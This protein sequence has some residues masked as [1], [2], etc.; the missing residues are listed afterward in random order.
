MT[1]KN[2]YL[3]TLVRENG[4]RDVYIPSLARPEN[5]AIM[6]ASKFVNTTLA[7]A[8]DPARLQVDFISNPDEFGIAAITCDVE[9]AEL[10]QAHTNQVASVLSIHQLCTSDPWDLLPILSDANT[11]KAFAELRNERRFQK[12]IESVWSQ[13][14]RSGLKEHCADLID[15][16]NNEF[17][18]FDL[19][20]IGRYLGLSEKELS[21]YMIVSVAMLGMTFPNSDTPENVINRARSLL[22]IAYM[23]RKLFGH[24]SRAAD[25]MQRRQPE[26]WNYS[27]LSAVDC[28]LN[29]YYLKVF[30]HLKE[31]TRKPDL[32]L[33]G[34]K[35]RCSHDFY[36]LSRRF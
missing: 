35:H 26:G 21:K 8:F 16:T 33:C 2:Q 9:D 14:G 11:R 19:P 18:S 28:L 22:L 32:P 6:P 1:T 20:A 17:M 12:D 15:P 25:W 34:G 23:L 13:T 36:C 30:N 10:I 3:V 29:G 31:V 24:S 4:S 7:S 5:A 27:G